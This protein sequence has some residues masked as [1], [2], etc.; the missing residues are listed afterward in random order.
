MQNL[1]ISNN[2]FVSEYAQTFV[3]S[4]FE[5]IHKLQNFWLITMSSGQFFWVLYLSM[6]YKVYVSNRA[7][8]FEHL[9]VFNFGYIMKFAEILD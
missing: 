5:I 9:N 7:S 1:F 2:H 3:L 4:L 8:L 6:N